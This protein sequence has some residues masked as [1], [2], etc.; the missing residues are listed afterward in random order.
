M[1]NG[2]MRECRSAPTCL[3]APQMDDAGSFENNITE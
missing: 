1:I 3:Q 2:H